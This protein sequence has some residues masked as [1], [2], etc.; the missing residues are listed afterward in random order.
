MS[1]D[2]YAG[3][4]DEI[5]GETEQ[6]KRERERASN[7]QDEPLPYVDLTLELEPRPWFIPDRIPRRNVT[8]V[9]GEGSI[10]KSLSLMQLSAATVLGKDWIGTLPE[11]G[12]VL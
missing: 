8:L 5:Y 12:P 1:N 3:S 10:G 4:L 7:G 11:M 6:E 2:A 9:S